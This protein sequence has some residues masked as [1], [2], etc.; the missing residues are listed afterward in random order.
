MSSKR[1][2]RPFTVAFVDAQPLSRQAPLLPRNPV[3]EYL[4]IVWNA[5]NA[6]GADPP[7]TADRCRR[8]RLVSSRLGPGHRQ[9]S[10]G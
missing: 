6:A 7:R 8:E 9:E 3:W 1:A 5:V 4:D 10:R 2:R